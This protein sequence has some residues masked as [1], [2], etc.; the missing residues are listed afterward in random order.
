M[1]K[2]I[3]YNLVRTSILSVGVLL[4]FVCSSLVSAEKL[5]DS[6]L[7]QIE[8]IVI[9]Y[10]ENR[11]F[12]NLYG[13]FPGANG[14]FKN[15]DGTD[16]NLAN[17]QQ[18]DRDGFSR[19]ITLPSVWN[20]QGT[21]ASEKLSFLSE[22]PNTP[23]KIDGA[24]GALPDELGMNS[25]TPDLVHRFFNNQMQINGGK[26]NMFAA[27]SDAGGLA[28]GYYDGAP[29]KMWQLARQ[30]TL[31]DN[32]FMGAFGGSFLNHFW[33]VCACTPKFPN[34][35]EAL[36]SKVN[37]S[38]ETLI[39]D[40]SSPHSALLGKPI[41][42]ADKPLTPDYY[43]VNTLQ[44][45][46]QPSGIAPHKNADKMIADPDQNPLPPQNSMVTKTIGDTLSAKG[47][48]WAWYAGG[49]HEATESRD[50]IYNIKKTN[51]QAHHQPFNYFSRF[52]PATEEGRNERKL[53]LKDYTDLQKDI[54][55]GTLPPV[56]FYKPQGNLNQHPGYA[57]VMS[58]DAHIAELVTSLKNSR[59][60][61]KMAIIVTYDEN[62]GY[63]DHVAPP[64]GDRWGPGTRIP[65]IIISPFSKTNYVDHTYYDTT[66][67]L[68]L[69][70]QRFSLE[71]IQGVRATTGNLSNAFIEAK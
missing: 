70:T 12:D 71:S 9:I 66:S 16:T 52:N 49:W 8:T 47:V 14:I 13:L 59:Q 64:K 55:A 58:G 4:I 56:V 31:T 24:P 45:P 25:P 41:Y 48:N 22:L 42:M 10:A 3:P 21:K 57:D 1:Q 50:V 60:W 28:M 15:A 18:V 23:F 36:L 2:H 37:S 35:P 62:G 32:F 5:G 26:N 30:Y 67:I 44:P 39:V 38:G 65:T 17:Y 20:A 63:W 43:A 27:W 29:M 34:A 33:L 6:R 69:I 51:F 53:H 11:S 46:Y 68:K 7:S 19:L 61:Q 40:K 54:Q